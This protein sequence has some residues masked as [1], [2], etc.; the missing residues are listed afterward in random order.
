MSSNLL[1][2]FLHQAESQPD[3]TYLYSNGRSI[4]YGQAN[5]VFQTFANFIRARGWGGPTDTIAISTNDQVDLLITI[6]ACL[7]SGTSL[8][9][10]PGCDD[11]TQMRTAMAAGGASILLTDI[12]HMYKEEWAVS[13]NETLL[14]LS[15]RTAAGEAHETPIVPDHLGSAF[16]FQTSG[17]EGE[18][19][20]VQCHFWKCIEIVECMWR[21]GALRHAVEQ[22]VYLTPP[23]YHS[24]GL[25]SLL[26]YTRGGSTIVLPSGSSP[27]GPVGELGIKELAERITAIEAVPHF[28]FQYSRMAGRFPLPALRHLGFGGGALDV[29]AVKRLQNQYPG[30]TYS[31]R[32]GLTE[33][34]SVVG[35]KIFRPPYEADW[36]S[37]GR[38]MPIYRLEIVG[39]SGEILGPEQEGEIVVTGKCVSHYY[40][41]ECH[42]VENVLRTGDV[43][44]LTREGELVVV[45][46]RSVFLKYRG[47]RLSPEHIESVIRTF[48]AVEDCRVSIRDSRLVVEVVLR[49]QLVSKHD[50]LNHAA[51][52]LPNYSVPEEVIEVEQIPRTQSGKIKRH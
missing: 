27:L 10:C 12:S 49:D 35:H 5:A 29:D 33:T 51:V 28:Y 32:Y 45:G 4:S 2:I 41:A 48:S 18:P 16:L 43:G 25:S 36:R 24:Y 1:Q 21:E 23:L 3:R 40:G 30:I 22:T 34:P 26:E 52:Q 13:L 9:F 38:I 6:W 31:V 17:T 8:V 39:A 19:K 15:V 44:Y 11:I 14:S 7:Y 42:S 50:L 47:F 20:W 46:R 37:S